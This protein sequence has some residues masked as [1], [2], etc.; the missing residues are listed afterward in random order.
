MTIQNTYP[1]VPR[2]AFKPPFM[3][4]VSASVPFAE[5]SLL[6]PLEKACAPSDTE[7]GKMLHQL[8]SFFRELSKKG[9][10]GYNAAPIEKASYLNAREVVQ[11]T[12]DDVLQLWNVFPSPNGTISFEFKEKQ[13]ASMS[14]GNEAFS[15]VALSE[16]GESIMEKLDF[17]ASKA[18]DALKEMSKLLGYLK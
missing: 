17:N 2:E 6:R 4:E 8:D 13:I 14:V 3:Q 10:D 16:K 12:P 11:E 7:K 1:Q 15:Y 9:W 5:A 18:A